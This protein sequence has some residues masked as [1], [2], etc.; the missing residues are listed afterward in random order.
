MNEEPSSEVV[1]EK[2]VAEQ[3]VE[4]PKYDGMSNRAALEESIKIHR[5][6]K[7]PE[8]PTN[9]EVA[10]AVT[11][12]V[13]P[14]SEFSKEA[15]QAW[16]NKDIAAI[17]KEYRRLHD[18]RTSEISRAQYAEKQARAEAE[19]ERAE[20]KTWRELGKM[21]APYIEARGA[22]GV[23]PDKAIMEALALV[24]EFKK[25]DPSTVK[26]ELKRIGIDLDKAP[27]Q[28]TS[29]PSPELEALQKTVQ[30]LK[31]EKEKEK[32]DSVAQTFESA[33]QV[34]KAQ[35]TR[36]GDPVFP[37]LLLS[38]DEGNELARRIGSRTSDPYFR[39]KVAER[40][41]D[42]DFTV[43]VREAYKA[44]FGRVSGE[45]VQVSP[46]SNQHIAKSR[47]AAAAIPGR[48]APRAND[49]NLVGKLSNRAAL[50][51][52]WELHREGR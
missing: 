50:T 43:L 52:A 28:T 21:A 25:G 27:T 2:P 34:L 49:S 5:E 41:P 11:A 39:K 14:P 36:T 1:L 12:D 15:K 30:E 40:F 44:E 23:S 31:Q 10:Q 13:E 8:A 33:F 4:V 51:K 3:T 9:R 45:P 7:E 19:K 48:T 17:Q 22:E 29:A 38:G 16:K 35:K 42:A 47:R 26:A 46:N 37:D 32:F 6:G 20:A 18:S 24:N